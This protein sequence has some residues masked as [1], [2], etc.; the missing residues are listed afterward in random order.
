MSPRKPRLSLKQRES[1]DADDRLVIESCLQQIQ[2]TL[3]FRRFSM[4]VRD[5]L[6]NDVS[7][8]DDAKSLRLLGKVRAHPHFQAVLAQFEVDMNE[9]LDPEQYEGESA[10][11][12]AVWA[13]L[14]ELLAG[15]PCKSKRRAE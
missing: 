13:L 6:L 15:E 2:D 4:I 5:Q 3:G 12:S 11:R 8:L 14:Y 7:R 10:E 9:G 1:L